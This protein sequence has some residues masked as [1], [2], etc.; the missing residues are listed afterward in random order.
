ML[1][2]EE[3]DLISLKRVE[4]LF[5]AGETIIK[6]GTSFTHVVCILDG[7]VKVYLESGDRKNLILSLIRG[8]EMIG[9]PGL[10]HDEKHHFTVVAV[11]DTVTCFVDRQVIEDTI[12]SNH[13]FAMELLKRANL[14]DLAHFR[15][16]MTLSRKQM[17]GRVAEMLLYLVKDVYHSNPVRLTVSRQDMADIASITKESTIRILKEFK[18]AGLI[19]LEGPDLKIQNEKALAGISENG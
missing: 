13:L 3:L 17:P 19:S 8:G 4:V 9:S 15:K 11:E 16:M 10:F 12:R 6:Q 5:N 18:D 1:T 2:K 14:R 7:L